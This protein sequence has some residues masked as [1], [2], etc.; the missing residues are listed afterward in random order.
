MDWTRLFQMQYEL[1]RYIET[2][3]QVE[4]DDLFNKK[5]LA[6]MVEVGELANET[7]TFKFWSKKP[8]SERAVILEEYVD[9]IHF[10]MSLGLELGH[11][12]DSTALSGP[13]DLTDAFHQVY[14]G[15]VTLKNKQDQETYQQLFQDYLYLGELL[16]FSEEDIVDAY[17]AKNKVNYERQQNDY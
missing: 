2:N 6:L 12:Y 9:G 5:T 4:K 11:R 7:R 15:I 1:D 3:Q 16:G 13:E 10:L 17:D 14:E 8:A